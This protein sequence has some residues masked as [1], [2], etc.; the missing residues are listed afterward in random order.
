MFQGCQELENLDL[1]NFNTTKVTDMG[2]MFN[3]CNKSKEIK[4][5]N[6]FNTNNALI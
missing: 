2:F 3:K 4:G 6:R 1:S 5:I